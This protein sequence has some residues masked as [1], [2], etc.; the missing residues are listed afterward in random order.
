M[1]HLTMGDASYDALNGEVHVPHGA[2]YDAL[3]D[4]LYCVFYGASH[5]ASHD[6]RCVI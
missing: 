3:H 4:A 5:D 2:S 1:T 6:G